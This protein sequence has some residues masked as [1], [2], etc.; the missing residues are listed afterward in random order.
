[1]TDEDLL[2]LK[3]KFMTQADTVDAVKD[4]NGWF[5]QLQVSHSLRSKKETSNKTL[6]P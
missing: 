4:I 1:M 2:Y 5:I 6:L 3:Y